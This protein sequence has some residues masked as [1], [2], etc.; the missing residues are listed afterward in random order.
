M[1][2]IKNEKYKKIRDSIIGKFCAWKWNLREGKLFPEKSL[3]EIHKLEFTI[4]I[5]IF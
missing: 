1:A 4:G 5:K 2:F 3:L